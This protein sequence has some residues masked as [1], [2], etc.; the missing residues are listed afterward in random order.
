MDFQTNMFSVQLTI[1]AYMSLYWKGYGYSCTGVPHP[2]V[3]LYKREV[4]FSSPTVAGRW[5]A[6]I[7]PRMGGTKMGIAAG[8]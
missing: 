1:I 7:A 8:G 2:V 4:L 6:H 5:G 3:F